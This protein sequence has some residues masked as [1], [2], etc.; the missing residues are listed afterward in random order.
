LISTVKLHCPASSQIEA[1]K[2]SVSFTLARTK[3]QEW[4]K[5]SFGSWMDL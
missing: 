2:S 5:A 1:L 3:L 4:Q